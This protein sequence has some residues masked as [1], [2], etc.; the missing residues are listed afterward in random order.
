MARVGGERARRHERVAAAAIAL[1]PLLAD[2]STSEAERGAFL[3]L[4]TVALSTAAWLAATFLT[5][6]EDDATLRRF[7]ERVQPFG[8]GWRSVYERLGI[9]PPVVDVASKVTGFVAG[10]VLVYTT[11]FGIG[12]TVLGAPV[13]G[14]ALLAVA[15]V[16]LVV[17]LRAVARG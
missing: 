9:T 1:P 7:V 16:S 15:A 8:P 14:A 6:P 11:T 13:E 2:V 10:T 4:G 5:K 3:L 12:R 17:V